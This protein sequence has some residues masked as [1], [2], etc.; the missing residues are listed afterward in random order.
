[1]GSNPTLSASFSEVKPKFRAT[2]ISNLWQGFSRLAG[3]SMAQA[4]AWY[5]ATYRPPTVE[6]LLADAVT[7][8]LDAKKPDVRL[9]MWNDYRKTLT[10]LKAAF[11]VAMFTRS[12]PTS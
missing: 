1:M 6:K 11:Q 12:R 10:A 7:D 5:V 4:V 3:K 8:F 2:P 9:H